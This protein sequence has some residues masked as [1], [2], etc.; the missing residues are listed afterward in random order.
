MDYLQ[1]MKRASG[2]DKHLARVAGVIG[3]S[4]PSSVAQF[5]SRARSEAPPDVSTGKTGT[6]VG[7]LVGG[8][9]SLKRGHGVLGLIGGGSLGRNLP[10]LLHPGERRLALVNMGETGFAVACA[11][12]VGRKS[13]GT[14]AIAF[15]LGDLAANLVTYYAGLRG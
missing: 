4:G 8:A 11:L 6:V 15:V 7:A 10:A 5:L 14:R 1:H 12:A 9:Y 3:D 13:W 2:A